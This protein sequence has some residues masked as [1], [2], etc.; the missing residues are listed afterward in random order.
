MMRRFYA[1]WRPPLGKA[2]A[3]RAAQLALLADLR[4]G[5]VVVTSA[6]RRVALPEDPM[7]WA[8]FVL[9]GAP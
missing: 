4:A 6:G 8:G 9:V 1:S 5:R 3:L 7:L 2:A